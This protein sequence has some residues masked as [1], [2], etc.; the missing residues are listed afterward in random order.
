MTVDRNEEL[1]RSAQRK[2]KIVATDEYKKD[3]LTDEE[4]NANYALLPEYAEH[5]AEITKYID[6][7]C[8]LTEEVRE[9]FCYTS[10]SGGWKVKTYAAGPSD[11]T[12]TGWNYS[13]ATLHRDLGVGFE[14]APS[15]TIDRNYAWLGHAWLI[16]GTKEYFIFS[17]DYCGGYGILDL[18]TGQK[19]IYKS[20]IEGFCWS[21]FKPS[22]DGNYIA[23]VGCF[24]AGPQEIEVRR[25]PEDPMVFP[26]PEVRWDRNSAFDDFLMYASTNLE[27]LDWGW[28]RKESEIPKDE[29]SLPYNTLRLT[30]SLPMGEFEPEAIKIYE[31][32]LDRKF[33]RPKREVQ[34]EPGTEPPGDPPKS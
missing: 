32:Y 17:E 16:K 33:P 18:E 10:P 11:P 7:Q 15:Y 22:L 26:W 30:V 34:G 12:S 19:S 27:E 20:P 6:T 24:W 13:R 25:I 4:R 8:T 1:V 23:V 21:T 5:R 29:P 28:D 9:G 2:W 31:A 3:P 14:I